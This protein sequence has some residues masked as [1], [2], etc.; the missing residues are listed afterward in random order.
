MHQT[1]MVGIANPIRRTPGLGRKAQARPHSMPYELQSGLQTVFTQPAPLYV[2]T[3]ALI[4]YASQ[5]GGTVLLRHPIQ[6][7]ASGFELGSGSNC[8]LNDL[9]EL[10]RAAGQSDVQ[11]TQAST[12]ACGPDTLAWWLPPG[13]RTLR[14]EPAYQG[15]KTLAGLNGTPLPHPGLVFVASP[16]TLKVFAVRGS[17]RPHAETPLCHAPYWNLFAGG[18]ICRGTARYPQTVT[19]QDQGVW[20]DAFFTSSFTH[21]SRTHKDTH[22]GGS[23]EELLNKAAADGAFPENVLMDAGLSLTGALR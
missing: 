8:T 12:L 15:T 17:E 7:Y 5:V 6:D 9:R 19:P 10:A 3:L 4:V 2:P 20:E 1:Q 13:L 21:P 23:Y 18:V 14:F 16:G 11:F 22:W